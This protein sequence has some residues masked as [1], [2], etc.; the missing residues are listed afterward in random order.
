MRSR[1]T[2]SVVAADA[3]V[4]GEQRVLDLL[5]G[6]LVEDVAGQQGEQAAAERRLRAREP[7]AQAGQP[8]GS[9]LGHLE[10][11]LDRLD[12][13][14]VGR[15]QPVAGQRHGL[16]G[17]GRGVARHLG[18]VAGARAVVHARARARHGAPPAGGDQ[19]DDGH[20]ADDEHTEQE[21]QEFEH[22]TGLPQPGRCHRAAGRPPCHSRGVPPAAPRAVTVVG[23]SL[24][25]LSAARALR[26]AGHD[27][28][29]V[30]VGAEPRLPYD[31]PPLSKGLLTGG[32]PEADLALLGEA[33]ADLDLQWRLGVP[34][35]GL[36]PARHEVLLA[37][38]SRVTG[39][40]VVLATGARPRQL[41]GRLPRSGVHVLRTLDDARALRA[42]LALGGPLVVVGGGFLGGEV[43]SSARAL[44]LAVTVVEAEDTLLAAPLGGRMG[45][46]WEQVHADAGVHV[47]C[48]V[49][50][51]G[52]HGTDRVTA[53][54]LADGTV[55]PAA[56]VLVAVGAVPEVGWLTGTGLATA[57]GVRTDATGATAAPGVVAVGDCALSDDPRTGRPVRQEHWTHALRQ[58]A[59]AAATLLGAPAPYAEV[60]YVWSEQHG[61]HLQL[62]GTREPGDEV[63]VVEGSTDERSFVATYERRGQVVA[64]LGVA[65]PR[66]FGRWRRRLRDAPAA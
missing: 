43:A 32:T 64:V 34:A 1:P 30:L 66:E 7:A 21:Q 33:D 28:R 65:R 27:G 57:D 45:A 49:P 14:G 25:G 53:V 63:R 17:A 18:V 46:L 5:P 29:L 19:A 38:G 50:V 51:A 40:A 10:L 48:G 44:G 8:A 24:A 4:G 47:R 39:D 56:T 54:A 62:A 15:Q 52:L 2:S 41:R 37:D 55:L 35:T 23:A 22:G 9:G 42:D 58:P 13:D 59:T 16:D 31:R 20:R 11:R 6:V 61:L 26:A 36:D 60:P 3:H 12:R